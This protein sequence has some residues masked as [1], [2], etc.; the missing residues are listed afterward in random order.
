MPYMNSNGIR[1][2]YEQRGEGAPV[3]LIGGL[4]S[5]IE[6]W[7]T[8]V[9]I[10]KDHFRVVMFDNRGSG[11]SDKP[12]E[13]YTIEDMADDTIGLLN[14]LGIGSASFVGKS[15]GGMISQW[16]AIKYPDRVEKVVIGC[17]SGSRDD[18]G[19]EI[20]KMGREVASKIGMKAVWFTALLLGYTRDYIENNYSSIN[21]AMNLIPESD[22]D[23]AGYIGQ[24]LACEGHN[25]EHLLHKINAPTLILMGDNDQIV[26]PGKTRKLAALIPNSVLEIFAGVGHGFWRERQEHVDRIVLDFLLRD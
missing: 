10:Y 20:L 15:M 21:Q 25:I 2:F 11:R 17:T 16:I 24:S 14:N 8:Q 9:P 19:N 23:I 3:V 12:G 1:L 18:V 22:E 4:G 7:A 5:Q 6:S 13:S 26:S